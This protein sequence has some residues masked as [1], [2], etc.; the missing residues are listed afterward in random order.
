[1]S[2]SSSTCTNAGYGTLGGPD[3][4][5]ANSVVVI[6]SPRVLIEASLITPLSHIHV[7]RG[8]NTSLITPLSH[9]H[10]LRGINTSLITPLSH[11]HVLRGINTSLYKKAAQ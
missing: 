10:V 9:I 7:L 4:Q 8:I 2:W 5:A 11:I 3:A 1:M 6:S